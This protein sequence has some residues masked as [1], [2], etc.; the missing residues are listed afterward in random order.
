MKTTAANQIILNILVWMAAVL[1]GA[2]APGI[3]HAKTYSEGLK[4]YQGGNFAGAEKALVAAAAKG[5]S[6]AEKVKIYKLLGIVQYTRQN[7]KGARTSFLATL[8]IDKKARILKSE[9]LD[10]SVISFFEDVRKEFMKGSVANSGGK[11][12]QERTTP[13]GLK[14]NNLT[15]TAP[16]VKTVEKQ[17]L[18]LIETNVRATIILDGIL[19]GTSGTTINADPGSHEL[20]VEADGYET[21]KSK[22]NVV[23]NRETTVQANLIKKAAPPPPPAPV[24]VPKPKAAQKSGYAGQN[25]GK[26]APTTA[27]QPKGDRGKS[28]SLFGKPSNNQPQAPLG[29]DLTTE[30]A[31]D[32]QYSGAPVQPTPAPAY[33]APTYQTPAPQPYQP[34]P[35]YAP[36]YAPQPY[37]QPYQPP[38][39][40]S[41]PAPPTYAPPPVYQ[42]PVPAYPQAPVYQ[43]PAPIYIAPSPPPP[44][45]YSPPISNPGPSSLGGLD[46]PAKDR[47]G[48]GKKKAA[49]KQKG[50]VL[51]ALLPLGAGQFQNG[52]HLLGSLFAAAQAGGVG[53]YF[54][55]NQQADDAAA[56]ASKKLQELDEEEKSIPDQQSRDDHRANMDTYADSSNKYVASLQQNAQYGLYS[57]IGAYVLSASLALINLGDTEGESVSS[58]ENQDFD[59]DQL[60]STPAQ[61]LVAD[62]SLIPLPQSSTPGVNLSLVWKF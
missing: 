11:A 6:P 41:Y 56:N 35:Q 58:I 44:P 12:P 29:R 4:Q 5:P 62:F 7:K 46:L 8:R 49:A 54:Y 13:S 53:F 31:I 3:V 23:E 60:P 34:A 14:T 39:A 21:F 33:P 20:R 16:I 40:P 38:M 43:P 61:K 30:F 48:S 28:A 51:V 32:S 27:S 17:T 19:A 18:L 26:R 36:Q 37:P 22:V 55:M 9:V 45:T 1:F 57:G 52:Q 10:E 2:G 42:Q 59:P 47:K 24:A 25:T 15:G 50:S